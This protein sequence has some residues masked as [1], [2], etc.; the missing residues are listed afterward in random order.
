[1]IGFIGKK[2]GMTTIFNE[3]GTAVPV[4]I[5][6]AGPCEVIQVKSPEKDGYSAIQLGFEPTTKKISKPEL[7][8][9][10]KAGTKVY[11]KLREFRVDDPQNYSVG[12][13]ITVEN[14]KV[15]DR[16]NLSGVSKGKGFQGV[17][18]R[19]GF[20]GGPKTHGQSNK[21]NAPGSIGQS[22]S[23]S[24]VF[25]GVK[26]PGRMGNKKVTIPGSRIVSIDPENNLILVRGAVVG[27][28]GEYLII[29]K[30]G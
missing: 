20:A 7:G 23:P 14:F 21:W 12:Q 29:E 17:R 9:F 11:K 16:V 6:L 18:K 27:P 10:K 1:M 25:K 4:T 15:G 26:M 2:V 24:R 8:H 3:D 28:K 5:L 19:H 30:K 13:L 22:A